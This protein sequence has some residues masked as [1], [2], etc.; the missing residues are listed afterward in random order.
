VNIT[1][2]TSS[3]VPPFEQ[4][5]AGIAEL[6][7]LGILAAETRLPSVRQLA[8]DLGLAPGTV[9]HAYT[10]LRT[11]GLVSARSRQRVVVAASSGHT[12]SAEV[13]HCEVTTAAR[14]Y[15][16]RCRR[17]GADDV[18]MRRALLDSLGAG[19]S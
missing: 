15:V 6:I 10:E 4:I 13:R 9:Q 3:P 12:E 5:R 17:L 14:R 16:E 19:T 11:A 8:T 7:A 18:E 1:V 2:D